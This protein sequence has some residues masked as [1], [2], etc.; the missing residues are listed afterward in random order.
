MAKK[1]TRGGRIVAA[2]K[3]LYGET[4]WRAAGAHAGAATARART[5]AF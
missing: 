4:R 5:A 1:L 3:L 2:G